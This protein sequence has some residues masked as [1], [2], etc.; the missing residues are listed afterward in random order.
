MKTTP[1]VISIN[2]FERSTMKRNGTIDFL[3]IY[4]SS[5]DSVIQRLCDYHEI[6][7]RCTFLRKY[8]SLSL[9]LTLALLLFPATKSAFGA[10]IMIT[11]TMF[12]ISTVYIIRYCNVWFGKEETTTIASKYNNVGQICVPRVQEWLGIDGELLA[13]GSYMPLYDLS[14][15]G[16]ISS[17]R[18]RLSR[19]IYQ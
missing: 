10:Y 19:I 2:T 5:R 14:I 4:P 15:I 8:L 7:S 3:V 6:I 16:S 9:F 11:Q 18:E 1:Q 13:P 12:F 17:R